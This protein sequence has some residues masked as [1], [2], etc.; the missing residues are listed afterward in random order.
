VTIQRL[1]IIIINI[2]GT[3]RARSGSII[4]LHFGVN[5]T[6]LCNLTPQL[7]PIL[8]LFLLPTSH[9]FCVSLKSFEYNMVLVAVEDVL[10]EQHRAW[11]FLLL[12]FFF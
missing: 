1:K 9:L 7:P 4:S 3:S 5:V 8:L 10:D 11:Y 6:F 2:P 12:T